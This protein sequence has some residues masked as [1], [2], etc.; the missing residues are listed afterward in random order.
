LRQLAVSASV[1]NRDLPTLLPGTPNGE[2]NEGNL[3]WSIDGVPAVE[4][5]E[6]LRGPT[7]PLMRS[8]SGDHGWSLINQLTSNHLAIAGEDP[9][10]A[11]AALRSVLRLYGPEQDAGWR[12]QVEGILALRTSQVTRRLPLRGPLA[13]GLG[14]E[15]EIEVDDFAYRGASAF[16]AASVLERFFAQQASIN[17]FTET[18]LRSSSRGVVC[19]WPVRLGA[20]SRLSP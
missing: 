18:K 2:I 10:F 14:T 19:T 13:Y 15:V 16:V 6:C 1:T 12:A 3:S 8:A 17:S 9:A 4:Q 7:R 20:V 11:A 5:V